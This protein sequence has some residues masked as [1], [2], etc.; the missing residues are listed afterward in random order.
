M[1]LEP[2][3]NLS[4]EYFMTDKECDDEESISNGLELDDFEGASS[5]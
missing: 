3:G 2:D 1:R 5:T 4:K